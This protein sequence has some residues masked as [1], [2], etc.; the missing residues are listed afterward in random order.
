MSTTI[1]VAAGRTWG[2]GDVLLDDGG[3]WVIEAVEFG[4]TVDGFGMDTLTIHRATRGERLRQ[5]IRRARAWWHWRR[6]L[7][8]YWP[9]WET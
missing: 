9:P 5:R 3:M 2:Y 6:P 4:T 1:T 7:W 8:T